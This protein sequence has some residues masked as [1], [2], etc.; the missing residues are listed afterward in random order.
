MTINHKYLE[1]MNERIKLLDTMADSTAIG[2]IGDKK[3]YFV[4]IP[5]SELAA[6]PVTLRLDCVPV[7]LILTAA[8]SCTVSIPP[9]FCMID[10]DSS[11]GSLDSE[12][13]SDSN[14]DSVSGSSTGLTTDSISE[15]IRNKMR[16]DNIISAQVNLGTSFIISYK[17]SEYEVRLGRVIT[18]TDRCMH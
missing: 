1:I 8:R 10:S 13:I 2:S 15:S 14:L 12:S 4:Y 17:D 7:T 16:V 3:R 18:I 5:Y 6:S 11:I 9:T